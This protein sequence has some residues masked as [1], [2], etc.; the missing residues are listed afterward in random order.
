MRKFIVLFLTFILLVLPTACS[1][2]EGTPQTSPE[3]TMEIN[4]GDVEAFLRGEN[5]ALLEAFN[6]QE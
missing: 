3:N 4:E 5:K 6:G 2:E 1:K